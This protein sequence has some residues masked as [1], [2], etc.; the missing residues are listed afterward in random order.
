MNFSEI[1]EKVNNVEGWMGESDLRTLYEYAKDVNGLIVEIGCY[2]GRSTTLLALASPNSEIIT[3]DPLEETVFS[4]Y[5]KKIIRSKLANAIR[6][7]NVTLIQKKSST[8]GREWKR[9]IDL[10]HIDGDHLYEA[11]KKD[12]KMFVP[13]VKKGHYILLHDYNPKP[14]NEDYN[15]I[16]HGVW[17]AVTELKDK[18][19]DEVLTS[20]E[21]GFEI[22]R[23]K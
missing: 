23:K 22:C 19:F 9:P 4:N 7:L 13:Y 2:L 5:S 18:Y 3:I 6:G 15:P 14:T 11:V 21:H 1:F 12:I 20:N 16:H 10:L 17:K 8:V